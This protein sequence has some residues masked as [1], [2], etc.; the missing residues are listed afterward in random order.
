M[1]LDREEIAALTQEYGGA[2]GINHCRRLLYLVTLIRGER[3]YDEEVVWLAVHLHD[4]GGYQPWLEPGVDH[5]VR[6][7][8]VAADFLRQREYPEAQLALV[9]EAIRT[10]HTADQD[11]C[12]EA[13]L[14][15]DADALDF[16][17]SIGVLRM[18]A[19]SARD[20]R[21]GYEAAKRRKEELPGLL[22]LEESRRLAAARLEEMDE[23]LEAFERGSFGLF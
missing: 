3:D 23:V 20:L 19:M 10:H 12:L 22:C 2:W 6:S 1:P 18:F 5:A 4:W 7:A 13:E 15:S 8:E 21:K 16:L 17:G 11:R 9:L 14:L